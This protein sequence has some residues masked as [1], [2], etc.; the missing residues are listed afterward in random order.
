MR[1]FYKPE[2]G[3]PVYDKMLS[4]RNAK[5]VVQSMEI[6][7]RI[8][9]E[10]TQRDKFEQKQYEKNMSSFVSKLQDKWK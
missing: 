9:R 1:P 7:Q 10:L 8:T 2:Q 5:Q 4:K 6:R 3:N